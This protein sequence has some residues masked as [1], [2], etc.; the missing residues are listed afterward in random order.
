MERTIFAV[1]VLVPLAVVGFIIAALIRYL[2]K[3][4]HARELPDRLP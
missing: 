2:R 1:F 4:E 3:K